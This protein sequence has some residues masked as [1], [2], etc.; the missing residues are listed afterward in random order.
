ML[1]SD[2]TQADLAKRNRQSRLACPL[3]TVLCWAKNTQEA[4]MIYTLSLEPSC[5]TEQVNS[6]ADV[7]NG[8]RIVCKQLYTTA[9]VQCNI[10]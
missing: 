1:L 8:A 3:G 7:W 6:S 10:L 9:A 2:A 5:W 4:G